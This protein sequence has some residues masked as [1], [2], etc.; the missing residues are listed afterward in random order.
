M[1]IDECIEINAPRRVVW[2][3]V[4]DAEQYPTF[5]SGVTR[6]D[7]KGDDGAMGKGARI[8]MRMQVGSAQ[9]GSLIEVVEFDECSELAWTSITG[10]EQRGRWRLREVGPGRTKVTLRLA[11]Q[12]PGGLAGWLAD[13]VAARGVRANLR[14]SVHALKDR[15]QEAAAHQ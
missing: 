8:D 13:H 2:D 14:R 10:I 7:V 3:I 5:M 4:A 1:R 9:V 11:Y 12:A 15:V 6:W